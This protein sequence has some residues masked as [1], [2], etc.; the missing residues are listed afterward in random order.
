MGLGSPKSVQHHE[1]K[2]KYFRY[3]LFSILTPGLEMASFVWTAQVNKTVILLIRLGCLTPL[4]TIFQLYHGGQFYWWRKSEYPEK[5][6]D[7]SQVTD[8]LYHIM[9]Y[10]LHLAWMGFELTTLVVIGTDCIGSCKSN[11]HTITTA[12]AP[13]S[14]WTVIVCII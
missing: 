1:S 13:H 6:T 12:T 3:A 9:L 8:K 7:L 11:Y 4:S 2:F 5:T 14:T 10:R